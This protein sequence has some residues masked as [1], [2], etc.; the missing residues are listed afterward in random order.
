MLAAGA[1]L[2][3]AMMIVVMIVMLVMMFMV[4]AVEVVVVMGMAMLVGVLMAVGVGMGVAVVDVLMGM[5]VGMGVVVTAADMVVI[6]MHSKRSFA[7]FFTIA[8]RPP[9]VKTNKIFSPTRQEAN[10]FLCKLTIF[11]ALY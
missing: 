3:G 6:D 1:A 2:V 4:V 11:L 8:Y 10:F 5:F 7:F 9:F